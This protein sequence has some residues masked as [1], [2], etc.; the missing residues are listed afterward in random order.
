MTPRCTARHSQGQAPTWPVAPN[1]DETSAHTA[2]DQ[3]HTVEEASIWILGAACLLS[4]AALIG[5]AAGVLSV[6]L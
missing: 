4:I 3:T 2:N 6:P 5:V 1:R